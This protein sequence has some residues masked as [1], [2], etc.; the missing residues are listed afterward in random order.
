[1]HRHVH[2]SFAAA[3]ATALLGAAL[4]TA[5]GAQAAAA[6]TCQGKDV[7]IDGTATIALKGKRLKKGRYRLVVGGTTAAGSNTTASVPFT[8]KR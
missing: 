7:T 6:V 3:G 2:R 8:L 1:M 5:P 4:L